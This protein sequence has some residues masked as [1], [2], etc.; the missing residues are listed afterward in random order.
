MPLEPDGN[1]LALWWTFDGLTELEDRAFYGHKGEVAGNIGCG[2]L[3]EGVYEGI[4]AGGTIC[5]RFDGT[6]KYV[7]CLPSEQLVTTDKTQWSIFMRFKVDDPSTSQ[8]LFEKF[9]DLSGRYS[10]KGLVAGNRVVFLVRANGVEYSRVSNITLTANTWY[11]VW[12]MFNAGTLSI[13]INGTSVGTNFGEG[14]FSTG[15][16]DPAGFDTGIPPI[17]FEPISLTTGIGTSLVVGVNTSL[18]NYFKG[19]IQDFRFWKRLIT[20]TEVTNQ[21]T[22]K[23]T[24]SDIEFERVAVIGYGP[25]RTARRRSITESALTFVDTLTA[26]YLPTNPNMVT[27]ANT[28]TF[29]D[30]LTPAV[31]V[32][33]PVNTSDIVSFTDTLSIFRGSTQIK[34]GAITKSTSTSGLPFTISHSEEIG[35]TPKFILFWGD[36]NNSYD[37]FDKDTAFT[38][39]FSD[40]TN[41]RGYGAS[42]NDDTDVSD[43]AKGLYDSAIVNIED[44]NTIEV[45]ATCT[46]S[47][48]GFSL[49]YTEND[50]NAR[51]IY[52]IA[53][54]GSGITNAKVGHFAQ[55]ATATGLHTVTGVGF[56]PDLVFL[57]PSQFTAINSK[58]LNGALEFGVFNKSLDRF[59]IA[60]VDQDNVSTTVSKRIS[61]KDRA[62]SLLGSE[63]TGFNTI[64][65]SADIDS[66]NSDGFVLDYII[67]GAA[68]S[69][70][71]LCAYG[72]IKGVQCVIGHFN[73]G[74]STG[75]QVI[76][77]L[78]ITFEPSAIIFMTHG[79]VT[80]TSDTP[81]TDFQFGMGAAIDSLN[82]RTSTF[83]VKTAESEGVVVSYARSNKSFVLMNADE[84]SDDSDLILSFDIVSMGEG[85]FTINKSTNTSG[86]ARDIHYIALA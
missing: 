81:S 45:L 79:L 5:M 51:I 25:I 74:T 72:A 53:F 77:D 46:F 47:P 3:A 6:E 24:I 16:F 10:Y 73:P 78:N 71:G 41:N 37:D 17:A 64:M 18:A 75:I 65:K 2:A 21:W 86:I 70:A 7:T 60:G 66:T 36:V 76:N 35:F 38:M 83:H 67:N 82:R 12:F 52:Y 14:G 13:Y 32:I 68:G 4:G 30:T 27:I 39:G 69:A 33:A 20:S 48:N 23:V 28:V 34:V 19:Y 55:P 9:D 42:Y 56:E 57:L 85:K 84:I 40:G 44:D 8:T 22:N 26:T 1:D 62:I 58:S 31:N 43:S 54:G 61:R 49:R 59:S 50:N 80:E 15:G 29:S 63:T 11:D